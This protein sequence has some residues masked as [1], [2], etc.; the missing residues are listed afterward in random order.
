MIRLAG[1]KVLMPGY[2]AVHGTNCVANSEIL[3]DILRDYVGFDGMVVSDYTAINQ[4]PGYE[5]A[6]QKAAAA[7]QFVYSHHGF[8]ALGRYFFRNNGT[9]RRVRFHFLALRFLSFLHI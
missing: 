7:I 4:L 9:A 5:N 3:Q 1:S 8:C 2:H 6:I